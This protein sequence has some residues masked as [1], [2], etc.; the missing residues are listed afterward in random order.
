MIIRTNMYIVL[1]LCLVP[2]TLMIFAHLSENGPLQALRGNPGPRRNRTGAAITSR[3]RG[4]EE[5]GKLISNGWLEILVGGL[6]AIFYFPTY[7]ENHPKWLSYFS[8]GFKP[9]TSDLLCRTIW[10]WT[11]TGTTGRLWNS[12]TSTD[13]WNRTWGFYIEVSGQMGSPSDTPT[14]LAEKSS[15]NGGL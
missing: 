6:V 2:T 8:E 9:P 3:S 4:C 14:R 10:F 11:T 15:K 12:G 7:W 5:L 1:M 13:F